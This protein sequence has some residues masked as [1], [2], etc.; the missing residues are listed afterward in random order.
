MKKLSTFSLALHASLFSAEFLRAQDCLKNPKFTLAI[1]IDNPQILSGGSVKL[2]VTGTN[3]SESRLYVP[4]GV[5]GI[6]RNTFY[7]KVLDETGK[8]V[9]KIDLPPGTPM[10]LPD[11]PWASVL[12]GESFTKRLEI[13]DLYH[14][15]RPDNYTIMLYHEQNIRDKQEGMVCS[16]TLS[17]T[18][19]PA[20]SPTGDSK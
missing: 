19:L 20:S 18:V 10:R 8:P 13:G 16:N 15:E 1:Q 9:A 2:H 14:F 11:N 4:I 3:V 7:I 6:E 5:T 17:I 12:P